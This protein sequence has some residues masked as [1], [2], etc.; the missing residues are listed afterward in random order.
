M[1]NLSFLIDVDEV[2][3]QTLTKMV[4]V[5]NRHF[6]EN[7][8]EYND[9]T[10]YI[11]EISFPGI[12]AATGMTASHW[13]FQ[14]LG[15]E[16]FLE[17]NPFPYI[18]EDIETLKKYGKVIILTYQKTYNNK[19]DTLE[20]LKMNEI[21]P[22]GVCF[23]KDK[24][25][26]SGTYM[27]DDNDWNFKGCGCKYG[28]LVE[29][30]YNKDVNVTVLKYSSCCDKIERVESLHEFVNKFVSAMNSLQDFKEKYPIDK[31]YMIQKGIQCNGKYSFGNADDLIQIENY[32]LDCLEPKVNIK[33][34]NQWSG[35]SVSL[36]E[37]KNCLV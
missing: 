1:K 34:K 7:K 31:T 33:I 25:I 36:E 16:L 24:T 18:K 4:E 13:F 9:I 2:L 15:K 37:F 28:M 5:Y 29:A 17:S 14:E 23:L 26:I 27:I 11:T 22:D 6:P 19:F 21:E 35:A 30:P 12:E 10:N 3:R 20:W 32:Y 8:L